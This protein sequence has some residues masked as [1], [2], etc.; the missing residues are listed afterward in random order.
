MSE[1]QRNGSATNQKKWTENFLTRGSI[2]NCSCVKISL[3]IFCEIQF[4]IVSDFRAVIAPG[5][6]GLRPEYFSR[7]LH[8]QNRDKLLHVIPVT[9]IEHRLHYRFV[10]EADI[11]FRAPDE[12]RLL[13]NNILRLHRLNYTMPAIKQKNRARR[14]ND[15]N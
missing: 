4:E 6:K 12:V 13:F 7:L 1:M 5:A 3:C 9:V 15:N 11:I 10:R 8:P 14:I 2:S